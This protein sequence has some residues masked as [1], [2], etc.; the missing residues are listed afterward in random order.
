VVDSLIKI[1]TCRGDG[2]GGVRQGKPAGPDSQK[3][4]ASW[5]IC[6]NCLSLWILVHGLGT[7]QK[8]IFACC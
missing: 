4:K 3:C 2:E 7:R 6:T 8:E 1:L 5:F